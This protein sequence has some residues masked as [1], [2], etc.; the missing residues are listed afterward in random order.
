MLG[1]LFL[2]KVPNIQVAFRHATCSLLVPFLI[3][4]LPKCCH[5][6]GQFVTTTPEKWNYRVHPGRNFFWICLVIV[7]Q[8]RNS[9]LGCMFPNI[10][11]NICR[12]SLTATG[13]L[14]I[15]FV[16]SELPKWRSCRGQFATTTPEKMGNC[17]DFTISSNLLC[18][19]RRPSTELQFY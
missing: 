2:N 18:R 7:D 15:P 11:L 6:R 4:E 5:Y 17:R 3:S 9:V 12:P 1:C 10:E 8:E 13:S 14:L 16:I 19:D